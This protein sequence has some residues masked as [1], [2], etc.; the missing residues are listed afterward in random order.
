MPPPATAAEFLASRVV[1]LVPQNSSVDD[2]TCPICYEE[3]GE[4]DQNRQKPALGRVVQE[5]PVRVP[6]GHIFG[7]RCLETH[8][9]INGGQSPNNRCPFCRKRFFGLADAAELQ[10]FVDRAEALEE[11]SRQVLDEVTRATQALDDADAALEVGELDWET[12]N[13]LYLEVVELDEQ[14]KAIGLQLTVIH[15]EAVEAGIGGEGM[16][17]LRAAN[18]DNGLE[19]D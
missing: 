18:D 19:E 10:G 3:Y 1:N 2:S 5:R 16:M 15:N 7:R 17:Q 13:K 6:C 14:Q 8:V 9:N 11:T 12:V 4:D